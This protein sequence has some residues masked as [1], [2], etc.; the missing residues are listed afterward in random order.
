MIAV[1]RR[2]K[3]L[4]W[5]ETLYSQS[6]KKSYRELDKNILPVVMSSDLY[7]QLPS[8]TPVSVDFL[9][10]DTLY[11]LLG[12]EEEINF[13]NYLKAIKDDKSTL[14]EYLDNVNE[15][16]GRISIT[17]FIGLFI[18]D[19]VAIKDF[20]N[21]T[22]IDLKEKTTFNTLSVSILHDLMAQYLIPK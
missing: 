22:G 3:L 6:L 14:L 20:K 18:N 2:S 21:K 7:H 10:K 9:L 12:K 17:D 16:D 5:K 11:L 1:E 19:K 15:Y 4:W 8:I 13:E